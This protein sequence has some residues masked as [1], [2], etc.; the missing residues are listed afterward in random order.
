[1]SILRLHV[2]TN[3]LLK[4]ALNLS[5]VTSPLRDETEFVCDRQAYGVAPEETKK[6]L[7]EAPVLKFWSVLQFDASIKGLGTCLMQD[8]HQVVYADP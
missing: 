1:M 6:I 8:G 5:E 7:S 2:L 4:F 3:Y